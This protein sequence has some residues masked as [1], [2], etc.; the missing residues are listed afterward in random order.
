MIDLTTP[1]TA[2][3]AANGSDEDDDEGE[4][5]DSSSSR[6]TKRARLEETT[7]EKNAV[8]PVLLQHAKQRLSKWAARLFDPNRRRGLVEEPQTIP[9]NDEF[10]TAFGKRE[11]KFDKAMGREVD[12]NQTIDSGDEEEADDDEN[13]ESNSNTESKKAGKKAKASAKIKVANLA[14][15]TTSETLTKA[16]EQFGALVDVKLILDEE[17][18]GMPNVFNSGRGYITFEHA[19][20]AQACI[21][22]LKNV[23]GR[24]LRLSLALAK[25]KSTNSTPASARNRYWDKDI[26]TVC[27]RCGGVGHMEPNC[28]NPAKAKPCPF[29]ASVDHNQYS[30]PC[31]QICFNCGIP[32][33]V[34]REC[35]FQRGLARR[36]ICGICF[37]P[38]HHRLQCRAPDSYVYSS[39]AVSND[40]ICLVCG[41]QGH[42]QCKELKWFYGLQG[43]SCF[44]CGGR[45]HLGYDCRRPNL[46]QC[47]QDP[48]LTKQEIDRATSS[49]VAEQMEEQLQERGRQRERGNGNRRNTAK[50]MPPP[51]RG[52]GMGSSSNN[53]NNNNSNSNGGRRK[54]G[55]GGDSHRRSKEG[56]SSGRGYD[57]S[58]GG[59]SDRK[60]SR[61]NR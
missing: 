11:K 53:S 58:G 25:P 50:S 51:R 30:C 39:P 15:R 2:A 61:G 59:G 27:F 37:Q 36:M 6:P 56:R 32:G 42:F 47:L 13:E 14:Y 29:C 35:G 16:C 33:H 54:S 9:L 3:S 7:G 57:T 23:D 44:N 28:T 8:D 18:A 48:G 22:G 34:S 17:R 1:S 24:P 10:L 38:G 12:V 26:S 4:V 41:K 21:D 55:G 20:D 40:A 5:D 19:D 49:S 43:L 45:G 60:R 52:G 31:K 46:F